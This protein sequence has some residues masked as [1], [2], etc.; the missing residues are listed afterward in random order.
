MSDNW[1]ENKPRKLTDADMQRIDARV[2]KQIA[3]KKALEIKAAE[4]EKADAEKERT[5]AER[6]ATEAQQISLFDGL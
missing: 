6:K 2:T 3:K 1:R 5:E 4:K